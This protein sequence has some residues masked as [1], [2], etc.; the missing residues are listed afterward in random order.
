MIYTNFILL[1]LYFTDQ[2]TYIRKITFDKSNRR[3]QDLKVSFTLSTF[4]DPVILN[5]TIT[6]ILMAKF[7]PTITAYLVPYKR[8]K[9]DNKKFCYWVSLLLKVEHISNTLKN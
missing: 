2:F 9:Y 8:E 3:V 6:V 4:V 7:N 5:P 1:F